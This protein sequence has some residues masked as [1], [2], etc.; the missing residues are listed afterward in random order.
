MLFAERSRSSRIDEAMVATCSWS[1]GETVMGQRGEGF[2]EEEVL[3]MG[4]I[5]C[6]WVDGGGYG[7]G[8]AANINS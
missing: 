3:V 8:G 5:G 6:Q 7:G 4:L 1:Q 2:L